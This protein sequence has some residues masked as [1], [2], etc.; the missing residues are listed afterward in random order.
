VYGGINFHPLFLFY[1]IGI[2]LLPLGLIFSIL[3]LYYRISIGTYSTGTVILTALFLIMGLQSLIFA[4]LFDMESNKE[5]SG[6][7]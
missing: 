4:M 3:V 1:L 6:R 5:L 2:I 7:K